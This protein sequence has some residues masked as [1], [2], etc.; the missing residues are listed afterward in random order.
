ML[1]PKIVITFTQKPTTTFPDRKQVLVMDFVTECVI[2]SSWRNLTDTARLS[3][4]KKIYLRDK[5]GN[6][7]D[8]DGKNIIAGN[9]VAPFLMRGDGVS[10]AACYWYTD[11]QGKEQRPAPVELFKGFVT[12]VSVKIPIEI[13]CENSMYLCKQ[14]QAPN[15]LFR[16]KDY[17]LEKM[18][19]E[20]IDVVN[21]SKGSN[22]KLVE[23][24]EGVT[25]SIGD[26]RCQNETVA[27]VLDRLRK[28]Y[29]VE[30]WF[31]GDGL[32]SSAIVYFPNEGNTNV[33]VF[34]KNIISDQ[35]QY[36]RIDDVR[37]GFNAFSIQK[38]ELHQNNSKGK[39]Q[40]LHKRLQTFVGDKDGEIRTQFFFGAKTVDELK[41]LAEERLLKFRYEGF[42]GKFVTFGEPVTFHGDKVEIR[43]T[44]LPERNG[45]YFVR[46]VETTFG[47]NGYRQEIELDFKISGVFTQSELNNGL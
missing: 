28:D 35:L 3:F 40:T 9:S 5:L 45:T 44:V 36:T 6:T 23:P 16:Q 2:V 1:R 38:E 20:L 30:S 11:E 14:V 22:L 31:R 7:F 42:K 12:K 26:F 15:K 46:G 17:T 8:L 10:I 41:K 37:L 43:D 47:Q 4:P 29:K 19:K 33:F 32:H 13:E 18:V 21:S 27:Q 39:R 34:Q 24:P 25:T